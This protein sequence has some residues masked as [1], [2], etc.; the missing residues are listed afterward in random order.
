M[1]EIISSLKVHTFKGVLI[2]LNLYFI[3]LY[4]FEPKNNS[5]CS[6]NII[7]KRGGGAFTVYLNAHLSTVLNQ[8]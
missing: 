3:K 6:L 5:Y 4:S 1:L 7:L 8:F 2:Y